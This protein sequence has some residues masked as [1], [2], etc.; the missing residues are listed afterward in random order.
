MWAPLPICIALGI[1]G[2]GILNLPY[3]SGFSAATL[4]ASPSQVH[5][6]YQSLVAASVN[7]WLEY[8]SSVGLLLVIEVDGS[9]I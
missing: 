8:F 2:K 7:P 5:L 6:S 9:L 4:G 1:P 3:P